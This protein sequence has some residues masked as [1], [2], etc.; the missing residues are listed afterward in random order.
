MKYGFAEL[1]STARMKRLLEPEAMGG[2]SRKPFAVCKPSLYTLRSGARCWCRTSKPSFQPG[3]Q[4]R[5]RKTAW[6]RGGRE[7]LRQ[8][9]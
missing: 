6:E 5:E 8:H 3:A 7:G 4:P 2:K 1:Y 9:Q